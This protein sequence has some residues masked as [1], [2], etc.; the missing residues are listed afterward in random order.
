MDVPS[1]LRAR[2]WIIQIHTRHQ[3]L[4]WAEHKCTSI[5]F[6]V[7]RQ[8]L[9]CSLLHAHTHLSDVCEPRAIWIV[10]YES[11]EDSE[12]IFIDFS[13][14]FHCAIILWRHMDWKIHGTNVPSREHSP[15]RVSK[16]RQSPSSFANMTTINNT[17]SWQEYRSDG[18]CDV[19][20]NMCQ[21]LALRAQVDITTWWASC[22]IYNVWCIFIPFSPISQQNEHTEHTH[23]WANCLFTNEIR[24]D[25]DRNGHSQ[26]NDI[27]IGVDSTRVEYTID[28]ICVIT[29]H[30]EIDCRIVCLDKLN[31]AE[32]YL[33]C[34]VWHWQVIVIELIIAE[35]SYSILP[36]WDAFG[37]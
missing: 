19:R 21:L 25:I 17:H 24:W 3:S 12:I 20:G 29:L 10:A 2:E 18:G 7:C 5:Y 23:T 13:L 8:H 16:K 15:F 31:V 26:L 1:V 33:V 9:I 14:F 32:S 4:H 6:V 37:T 28:S 22:I 27:G 30:V 11:G 36:L 34:A 35:N